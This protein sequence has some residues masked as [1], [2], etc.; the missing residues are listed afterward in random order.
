MTRLS[1]MFLILD[2]HIVNTEMARTDEAAIK[3]SVREISQ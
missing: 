2:H 1:P 3:T